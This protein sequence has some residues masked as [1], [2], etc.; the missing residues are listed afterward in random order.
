METNDIDTFLQLHKTQ[1]NFVIDKMMMSFTSFNCGE[2]G[3]LIL[4]RK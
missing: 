2:K 4:N 3:M 1:V